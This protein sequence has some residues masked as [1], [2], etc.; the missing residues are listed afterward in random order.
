[1]RSPSIANS[2][3]TH[4]H[5]HYSDTR[6]LERL[7]SCQILLDTLAKYRQL[8]LARPGGDYLT[9][10]SLSEP[11]LYSTF[12]R[13]AAVLYTRSFLGFFELRLVS[14][15]PIFRTCHG[16]QPEQRRQQRRAGQSAKVVRRRLWLF[17]VSTVTSSVLSSRSETILSSNCFARAEIPLAA[18]CVPSVSETNSKLTRASTPTRRQRL[19]RLALQL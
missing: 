14:L 4:T 8:S 9:F 18:A 15:H 3:R 16:S 19:R 10:A 2:R 7:P 5:T 11:L 12:H 17:C 13:P 6:W 1:M